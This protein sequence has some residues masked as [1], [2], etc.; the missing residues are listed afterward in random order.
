MEIPVLILSIAM[1][2]ACL[3]ILSNKRK[4][5]KL[6]AQIIFYQSSGIKKSD[7]TAE[8]FKLAFD[9]LIDLFE[10]HK[11]L[12]EKIARLERKVGE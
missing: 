11:E 6:E 12:E 4:I 2:F 10:K 8:Q 9:N 5:K 7:I 1:I 3:E